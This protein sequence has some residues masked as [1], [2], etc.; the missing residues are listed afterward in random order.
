MAI[1]LCS[2]IHESGCRMAQVH[3]PPPVLTPPNPVLEALRDPAVHLEIVRR[4]RACLRPWMGYSQRA[5]LQNVAEDLAAQAQQKALEKAS[6]FDPSRGRSVV[7]WIIGFSR[8][9]ARQRYGRS[10]KYAGDQALSQLTDKTISAQA[11]LIRESEREEVQRAL[12]R[13]G[14]SGRRIIELSYFDGLPSEDVARI[15]GI[16]A[17]NVRVKLFRVR[18]ELAALLSPKIRGGQS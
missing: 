15:L 8:N 2:P 12:G 14:A 4:T 18:K 3:D 17:V 6:A 10:R 13:I 11:R 1:Q 5:E 16:T 7:A 9:L